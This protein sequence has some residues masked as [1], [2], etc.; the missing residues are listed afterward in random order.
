MIMETES[1]KILKVVGKLEPQERRWCSSSLKAGRLETQ[2]ELV[3]QFKSKSRKTNILA[4]RQSSRKNP[5]FLGEGQPFV[6][7]GSSTD[8]MRPI[9][10]RED[11]LLT[12]S[13]DSK[14]NLI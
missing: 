10:I 3:F 12:Y 7:C 4:Q 13:T 11:N 8:W 14:I 5:L 6:L 9:N 1:P 2:E